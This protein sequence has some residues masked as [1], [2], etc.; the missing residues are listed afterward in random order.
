M[1]NDLMKEMIDKYGSQSVAEAI[2]VTERT[3]KLQLI[4]KRNVISTVRMNRAKI[5][6]EK[7]NA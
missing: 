3:V 5:K 6:L 7:N 1:N 2:G 4:S